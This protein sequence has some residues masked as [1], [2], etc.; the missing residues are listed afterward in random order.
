[1]TRRKTSRKVD[2]STMNR[3]QSEEPYS[4]LEDF[5]EFTNLRRAHGAFFPGCR[6]IVIDAL[7]Q[8]PLQQFHTLFHAH[9]FRTAPARLMKFV[10]LDKST[11]N[12]A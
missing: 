11:H 12:T 9:L 2:S 5:T 10:E 3:R 7:F 6:E 8:I 1:M 4:V